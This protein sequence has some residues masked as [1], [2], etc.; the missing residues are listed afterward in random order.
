[1]K[2]TW[3]TADGSVQLLVMTYFTHHL[4]SHFDNSASSLVLGS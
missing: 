2:P 3:Q 1:M 4:Q